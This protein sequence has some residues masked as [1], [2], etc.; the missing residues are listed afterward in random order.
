MH[1]AGSHTLHRYHFYTASRTKMEEKLPV[2]QGSTS[3]FFVA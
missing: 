1:P 2:R 3:G